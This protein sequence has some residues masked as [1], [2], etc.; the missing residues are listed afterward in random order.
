M[1]QTAFWGNLGN[2][3]SSGQGKE[4]SWS[5]PAALAD[6]HFESP[7]SGAQGTSLQEVYITAV[8]AR[9]VESLLSSLS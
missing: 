4:A 1:L 2:P 3:G 6:A 8:Q 9:G 7:T 5:T